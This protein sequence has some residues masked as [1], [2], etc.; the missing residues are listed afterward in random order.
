MRE[1]GGV[2]VSPSEK[3][4]ESDNR[5]ALDSPESWARLKPPS[6][7]KCGQAKQQQQQQQKWWDWRK[8]EGNLVPRP[9]A[10][11]GIFFQRK[12]QVERKR[13]G[14]PRSSHSPRGG[15]RGK[16]RSEHPGEEARGSWSGTEGDEVGSV[17][18]NPKSS[19]IIAPGPPRLS[20]A[21]GQAALQSS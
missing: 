21:G 1:A 18:L 20:S 6:E 8:P 11:S 17:K 13:Q 10:Q 19:S 7:R 16:E 2:R 15:R 14:V 4:P 9:S 12:A 3:G 5:G